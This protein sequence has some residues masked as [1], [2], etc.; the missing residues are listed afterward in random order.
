MPAAR[1]TYNRRE[2]AFA[3]LYLSPFL[4][5]FSA[6]LAYP[7]VYSFYISLHRV[8]LRTNLFDVFGNM[9]FV[10]LQ[11]YA[12]LWRDFELWWSLVV[13]LLYMLV[14]IPTGIFVSLVLALV[15]NNTLR[16]AS[17]FRAA[18]FLPNVLDMLV[19]GMIWRL[20]YSPDGLLD[21]LLGK[22]GVTFF[23][24]T[25]LLGN[26]KTA[27]AAVALAM[28][29]KGAGFGMV[30]F[31]TALQNI[32]PNIFE[33]AD[34]D[35]LSAAQK[36]RYITVPLL[37]PVILFMVVTGIMASLNAFTEFYIM[38]DGNPVSTVMG[39]SVGVTKITGYYLFSKFSEMRYG[40]SAAMSYI[41]LAFALALSW[42][43]F[44]FLQSDT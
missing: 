1:K 36:F 28:V 14:S 22:L 42:L 3:A 40:Y 19:I 2:V 32:S 6:F 44:K 27:L 5:V 37:K 16:G 10:G 35:G 15:L 26:P 30:L 33:A 8:T 25:G 12:L 7:I 24:E 9:S 31:L 11:N 34:I 21:F 4:I 41:L 17:V 39:H 13:T 23:H 43:N 20:I 18:F 29:I 38:T